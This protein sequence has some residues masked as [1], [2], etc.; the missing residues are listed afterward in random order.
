MSKDAMVTLLQNRQ[1]MLLA[2]LAIPFLLDR[3]EARVLLHPLIA[4]GQVELFWQTR[5]TLGRKCCG[6]DAEEHVRWLGNA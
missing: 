5:K 6:C 3:D 1:E 2:D 4:A